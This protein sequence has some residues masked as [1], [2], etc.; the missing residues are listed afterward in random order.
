MC[1]NEGWNEVL[2]FLLMLILLNNLL[3]VVS[4]ALMYANTL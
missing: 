3:N 1:Y 2:T 4:I